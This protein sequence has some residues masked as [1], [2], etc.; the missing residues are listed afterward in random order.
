MDGTFVRDLLEA[1]ALLVGEVAF[2]GD[3]ARDAVGEGV[4][5]ALALGAVARVESLL[6]EP[7]GDA[8]EPPLFAPRVEC[9]RHRDA[10]AERGEDERV[11]VCA[12]AFTERRRLVGRE[13]LTVAVAHLVPQI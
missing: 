10:T 5:L 4:R 2:D 1:R 7:H 3:V 12:R 6:P 9:E 8:L 11:R 13:G